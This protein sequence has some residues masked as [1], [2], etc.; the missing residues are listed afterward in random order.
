MTTT[1]SPV[2]IARAEIDQR[3]LFDLYQIVPDA[4]EYT[5]ILELERRWIVPLAEHYRR[6]APRFESHRELLRTLSDFLTREGAAASD[7]HRFLA[8]EATLE[9]FKVVV[10]EFAMDGLTESLSLL[11]VI[12]RLPYRSGMAV[13]RVMVDELG[14]GNDDMAHSEL[15]R[16]LLRE[17]GMPTEVADYRGS[18]QQSHAYVNMF[19]WLA[20]RAPSP[21]YFLGGYTYFEASVLYGFRSFAQAAKRLGLKSG[22]YYTEHLYIDMYHSKQMRVALNEM[23][24]ARDLDLSAVWSG[25]ELTSAIVNDATET[26]ISIAREK[27]R[28]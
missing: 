18:S 14:C 7:N 19:H 22:R 27:V 23:A 6:T 17:L 1:P 26:A 15:Y 3:R 11:P 10:G 9:Q 5:E 28:A 21:E 4:D 2:P 20:S 24:A 8:E 13:F 25:V 16:E 12:P